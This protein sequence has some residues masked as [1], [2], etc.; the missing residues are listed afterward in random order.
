MIADT[1]IDVFHQTFNAERQ[2]EIIY[3]PKEEKTKKHLQIFTGIIFESWNVLAVDVI[4][5]QKW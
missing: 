1:K 2:G 5:S 4:H 3:W